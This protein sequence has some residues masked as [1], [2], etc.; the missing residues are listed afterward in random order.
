MKID[1]VNI[2]NFR[3]ACNI[4]PGDIILYLEAVREKESPYYY[5]G[6]RRILAEIL[7]ETG[8]YEKPIFKLRVIDA[9]GFYAKDVIDEKTIFRTGVKIFWKNDVEVLANKEVMHLYKE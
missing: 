8:S 1:D 5:A 4:A 3:I 9:S 2:L 7:E 6:D